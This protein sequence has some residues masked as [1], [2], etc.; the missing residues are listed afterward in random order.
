MCLDCSLSGVEMCDRC[1]DGFFFDPVKRE[2]F[3]LTCKVDQCER[4]D[5]DP[6]TCEKC[7]KNYWLDVG[8]NQCVDG[9]CRV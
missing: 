1:A 4:C 2:C 3:D 6:F 7:V 5:A 9:K 8:L